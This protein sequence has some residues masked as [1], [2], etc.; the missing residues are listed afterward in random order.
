MTLKILLVDDSRSFLR[1]VRL[2]LDTL[3]EVKVI[4]Y[5]YNGRQALI[6]AQLL[7]PDL[8]LLDID[9]PDMNGFEVARALQSRP[10]PPRIVFLSLHDD[11]AYR[12]QA[13]LH[14]AEA[15]VSKADFVIELIAILQALAAGRR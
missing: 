15:L 9:M 13:H 4:G 5:A 8:V 11:P 10:Q 14:G 7:R 1:A 3:P 2:F 6:K 12:A